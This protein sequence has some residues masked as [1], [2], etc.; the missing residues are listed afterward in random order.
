MGSLLVSYIRAKADAL[1]YDAKVGIM[2]RVERYIVLIPGL[3][4][5]KPYILIALG[6]IAVLGNITAIQRFMHVRKQARS[7]VNIEIIEK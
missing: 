2:T 6:I 7:V 4:L 5:G 3:I 1:G